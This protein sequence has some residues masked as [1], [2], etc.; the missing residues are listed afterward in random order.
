MA[1][2]VLASCCA[3]FDQDLSHLA[4]KPIQ[5]FPGIIEWIFGWSDGIQVYTGIA[6]SMGRNVMP[7]NY[8]HARNDFCRKLFLMIKARIQLS[9]CSVLY[10]HTI[11]IKYKDFPIISKLFMNL[12]IDD[13]AHYLIKQKKNPY[14]FF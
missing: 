9:D 5:W 8:L 4:M 7:D 13:S 3:S 11:L 10:T 1:D 12:M 6:K 14:I 2:G